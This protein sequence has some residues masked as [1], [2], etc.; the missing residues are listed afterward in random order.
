MINQSTKKI[1]NTALLFLLMAPITMAY[2][3]MYVFNPA[4]AG[5]ILLYMLQVF[6]DLIALICIGTLWLTILLDI[7]QSDSHKREIPYRKKWIE[8]TQPS[9]DVLVPV[10]NEPLEIIENTL[11]KVIAMHYEHRTY[12]LDDGASDKT[13]ALAQKYNISYI[14]RPNKHYA[15]AGNINNALSECRGEFVTVFDADHAP[16]KSFLV[17]LLPY[18][19]NKNV[20]LVQSPQH[21]SNTK[22]FIASGTA[23]A[24]EVFYKYVQPAK[25]SYNASF[26]VG[27]NM[28]Y[29][30]SALNEIGG[31][32]QRDHSEDIWTSL[33]LHEKGYESIF[34]NKIL[35]KGLAPETII[36]F[37]AQQNR[38]ARGG[39][40]LFFTRNPL[41][42]QTL[43]IDQKLQY[44][45]SN[46][47]YFSGF[48]IL[49][50]LLIPIVYLM[51]GEHPMNLTNSDGWLGHY[52][53]YFLMVY[54]L[55]LFLLGKLKLSTIS[56]SL[57][58][59][60]PYVTAFFS[61]ILKNNF[62]WIATEA[63][64]VKHP[65][66]MQEIWAHVFLIALSLA[67]VVIGW[68]KVQD[69]PTTFYTSIWTLINSYL[70]F[71]FI[72]NG[73][74]SQKG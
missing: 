16:E 71:M 67:A 5:N 32:A 52:L 50:Y 33:L 28:I 70:L 72:T 9:V 64:R 6:A 15:K 38:W 46:I 20:A 51:T 44:F 60:Y 19:E 65:Y 47:H 40:V 8:E 73:M 41:F 34:Y 42:I 24:Q 53:P 21:F 27:T 11:K 59:F 1:Q 61:I 10:Y 23:Q 30:R 69:I 57:A 63:V 39:F 7:I 31:I 26:C 12:L 49:I 54:F 37:F 48:S 66:I 29:R 3:A 14:R 4:N 43:S 22:N 25:N 62:K 68:Y 2:Y 17:E 58:S 36:S 13:R 74:R 45:F 35:A 18:F 55:P 56:T